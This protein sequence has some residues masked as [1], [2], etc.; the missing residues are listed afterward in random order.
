MSPC[1]YLEQLAQIRANCS[2]RRKVDQLVH[3]HFMIERSQK[4]RLR[5]LSARDDLSM[6]TF[7]RAA[8]DHYL[9][10]AAGPTALELRH[11]ML[12]A[13]GSLPTAHGRTGNGES[14]GSW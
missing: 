6:A 2:R 3:V 5:E 13:V 14:R 11:Q 12:D 4:L 9:K 1:A 7:V 8:I 10:V